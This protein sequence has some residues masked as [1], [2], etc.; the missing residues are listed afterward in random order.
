MVQLVTHSPR[1]SFADRLIVTCW[2]YLHFFVRT[3]AIHKTHANKMRYNEILYCAHIEHSHFSFTIR[4]LFSRI[5][6]KIPTRSCQVHRYYC[7]YGLLFFF[8]SAFT[9]LHSTQNVVCS[10]IISCCSRR[11]ECFLFLSIHRSEWA[12]LVYW[13]S[14]Y[15]LSSRR[16]RRQQPQQK[17]RWRRRRL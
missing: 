15:L 9:S 13:I 8:L 5:N 1:H 12:S 17:H 6:S 16:R 14:V 11:K 3:F 7:C 2:F 4:L 10:F